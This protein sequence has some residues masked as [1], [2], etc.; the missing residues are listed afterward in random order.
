MSGKALTKIADFAALGFVNKLFGGVFSLARSLLILSV[1]LFF[2]HKINSTISLVKKDTL[3]SS[4]LYYP[5]KSVVPT[6]FPSLFEEYLE[7]GKIT[8]QV[9]I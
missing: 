5:I 8:D 1:L 3:E 9:I 4:I 6:L 7:N 2:F